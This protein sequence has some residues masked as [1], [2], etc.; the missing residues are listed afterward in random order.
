MIEYFERFCNKLVFK[1]F[2]DVKTTDEHMR[3]MRLYNKMQMLISQMQEVPY[4]R[5]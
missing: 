2:F 3:L 5:I 4:E 1:M